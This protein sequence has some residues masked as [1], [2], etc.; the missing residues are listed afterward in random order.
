MFFG[1]FSILSVAIALLALLIAAKLLKRFSWIIGW[2]RGT[3]GLCFLLV[4]VLV[5]VVNLDLLSYRHIL[6]E[7]PIVTLSFAEL[8]EQHFQVTIANL[9]SGKEQE[10]ELHGDQWQL[11]ARIIRWEGFFESFGVKPGYRL[12]RIG[13]RYFSLEDE[14]LKP[15]SVHEL[16]KSLYYVDAWAWFHENPSMFPWLE[17][18]YGSATFL[19]MSDGAIYQ[20]SLSQSGLTANPINDIAEQAVKQFL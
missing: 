9:D 13:G 15:R 2:L 20:V 17:A 7:R 1:V 8:G 14:R 5:V 18:V 11:D 6:Q 10:Y 16:E 4:A 19:P 3:I 12:E